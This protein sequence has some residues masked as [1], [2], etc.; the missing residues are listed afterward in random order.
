MD[1]RI[2]DV[3][4][5]QLKALVRTVLGEHDIDLGAWD[6]VPLIGGAGAYSTARSL[7]L[8]R[9]VA[10][11]GRSERPWSLIAKGFAPVAARDDPADIHYWKREWLLYRSGLLESLPV[12][13]SA[14]RC[15]GCEELGNGE[16]RLWLEHVQE[17][18][19]RLWPLERWALAAQHLGRFNGTY[20]HER[21]LP[22]VAWLGGRRLRSWV[23][24]HASLVARIAAA[25][26]NPEVQHWWPR[27]VV[28]A[29]LQLWTERDAMCTVLEGLPQTFC[30]G[31]AIRRNLF[32][33]GRP[34]SPED[35]VG[36]DW[37]YAGRYAV[38]EE[39]GQT[40]SVA[41]AFFDVTPAQL[42]ALDDALFEGYLTG[43]R[44][45]GW[46]GDPRLVRLAYSIHAALRNSFNAVGA[47]VPDEARRPEILRN[48]GHTWEELAERRAAIRPFLLER[49]DEA[50]RLID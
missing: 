24:H 4:S 48:Y 40:L 34:G 7:I 43:L 9:G 15:Y 28:D 21:R 29:I 25:P 10:Y 8:L 5:E 33:R 32:A 17:N 42:P 35:T 26:D 37:E 44:E 36:I 45:V 27:S 3:S 1:E 49:A 16:I 30:H 22:R 11:I 47:T 31:D 50:R 18:T 6:A 19:D 12:G 39:V 41:S 2:L 14:P 23:E 38:G 13:M 20:L 46:H